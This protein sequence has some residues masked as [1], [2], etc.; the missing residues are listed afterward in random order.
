MGKLTKRGVDSLKEPGMHGDGDGL[1]L[2]VSRSGT[3]SWILRTRIKG[4]ET[5]R[6]IGLGSASVVSLA[7]AR[8][9]ARELRAE[10][11]RG[12]NPIAKRDQQPLT[13]EAAARKVHAQ[14]LPTF[15]SD[16]H[17]AVWI[18]S[19]ERHAFPKFGDRPIE[20]IRRPDV[21]EA[22]LPIWTTKHDTARRVKQRIA[23]VFAWAIGKDLYP[24]PQPVDDALL[25]ALPRKKLD[26][27]HRSAL[28]WQDVPAFYRDLTEREAIAAHCLRFIVLTAVRSNEARGAR[29]NEVDLKAGTWEIPAERMKA[30]AAHRVPLSAEAIA[31]LEDARGLDAELVFPSPT[32]M[33]DGS[34]RPL[35]VNAFRPLLARMGREGFT[36]HGFRSSF[37]DWSSESARA[38]RVVAE[39]ALAHRVRGVEGA[40]ARSDLFERRRELMDAWARFVTDARGD[41][42][43]LV[44]A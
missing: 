39:A 32:R 11:R 25:S 8:D 43:E 3:K 6:E 15:R 20:T 41:V 26:P 27:E 42:V 5:R 22:L 21:M 16:K 18:T 34:A 40:Y 10:A 28:P 36:V 31:L 30:N 14:L 7:E 38:D 1:Y 37:R 9:K 2:S 4:E 24:H 33:K 23:S 35:S 29:W 19:L 17:G 13:F 44:R 12:N